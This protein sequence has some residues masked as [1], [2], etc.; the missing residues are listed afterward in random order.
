[1]PADLR[2]HLRVPEELFN[3]QTRTY[4]RYHVQDPAAFYTNE[5]LWTVP[6]PA[7][8]QSLPNEAYYVV[9]RMPG[10]DAPEFLL[11]QPMV[12]SKRPNMI[13][14]I[15]ARM[16]A[17]D[18][19]EIRVYRFPQNTSVLGPNQIQAKI[20]ADPIISAQTTLWDQSGS[21]VIRGNL[22]VM[23]IQDSL[24]YLQP[25]YLQS[26]NSA[27]PEFQRI[28]VATSQKIVWASTLGDAL[29]LLLA[30]G[31]G[32][33]PTPTPTPSPG[34]TAT[35]APT[36]TAGPGE[37]PPAGDVAALVAYAND[38]FEKAQTALRAGDFATYGQEMAKVQE[39][40]RQLD[41]LVNVSPA[42]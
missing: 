40:L 4:A 16:D 12:P 22:I 14:W 17:P 34:P 1:M 26:A 36:P 23:P 41:A 8:G 13:S 42:P 18:Y 3:V 28:V 31:T 24:I 27:F 29:S 2:A 7:G 19:G 39:A 33:T 6:A 9:M 30:G 32:P 20:D 5:D 35:P 38:H 37:T 25:V 10:E 21:H 15:A 11:L